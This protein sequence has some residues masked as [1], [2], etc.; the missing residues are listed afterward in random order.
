MVT[1]YRVG[2]GIALPL[3]AQVIA[4]RLVSNYTHVTFQHVANLS[5]RTW[6]IRREDDHR[7]AGYARR[8]DRRRERGQ[9]P[10]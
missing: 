8:L 10:R 2:D 4:P 5:R 6:R 9:A 1:H 3:A 7:N